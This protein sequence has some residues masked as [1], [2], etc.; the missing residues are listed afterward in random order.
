MSPKRTAATTTLTPMTYDQIKALIDQGVADALAKIEANRTN[1]N[2]DDSHDSGIGSRRTERA[3]HECT[4]NDFLK[5]QPLNFKGTEGVVS[6][7]Q[8][9][10][11]MEYW[12]SHVKTVVHDAAYGMSRKTLKNMMTDKYCPRGKIKKQEIEL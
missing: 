9:F 11:K 5:F 10:E 4:Y 3:A 8:W 2:G 12:N 1:R 7:T 6:L